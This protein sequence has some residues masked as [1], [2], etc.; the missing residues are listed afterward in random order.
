MD[1]EIKVTLAQNP[2]LKGQ[3]FEIKIL[4]LGWDNQTKRVNDCFSL[5]IGTV[6]LEA[7][8]LLIHLCIYEGGSVSLSSPD[9]GF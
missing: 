5:I 7:P 3:S 1:I 2:S 6:P 4:H 8:K 9:R